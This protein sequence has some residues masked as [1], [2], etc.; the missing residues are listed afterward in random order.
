MTVDGKGVKFDGERARL[1]LMPFDA[2]YE[3]TKVLTTARR[4]T[5][6][7]IGNEVWIGTV[8]FEHF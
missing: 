5:L 8:C 6:S 3:M 4:S 2:L 1:D 7:G